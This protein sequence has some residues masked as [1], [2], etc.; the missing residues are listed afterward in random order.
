MVKED[1]KECF[2]QDDTLLEILSGI[3]FPDLSSLL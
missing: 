2:S 3:S 1:T